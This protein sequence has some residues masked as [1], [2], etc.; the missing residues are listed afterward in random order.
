MEWLADGADK[1]VSLARMKVSQGALSPAHRHGNCNEVIHLL[2]GLVSQ[3]RGEEWTEMKAADILTVYQGEL[4]QTRNAGVKDAVL[5]I[6]YSSG[7]REYEEAY[8]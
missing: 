7:V 2:S 3:R 5:M 6:A 8:C 1:S 4:H